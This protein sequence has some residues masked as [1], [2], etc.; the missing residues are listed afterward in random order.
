M[1]PTFYR[2]AGVL[3][4][5][6]DTA[7][8]VRL[9]LGRRLYQPGAGTWTVPGGGMDDKDGDDFRRCAA[10]EVFE[11]TVGL[12]ELDAL[13]VQLLDRLKSAPESRIHVPFA[14]DFR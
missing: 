4:A 11:E 8:A 6:P 2:G 10:R 12:P 13:R 14:F 3:F 7:G 1:L 5:A 9:L